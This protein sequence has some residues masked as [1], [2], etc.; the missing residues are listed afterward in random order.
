MNLVTYS[1]SDAGRR[2]GLLHNDF[3]IDLER[4]LT[5]CLENR[6]LSAGPPVPG[7]VLEVVTAPDKER[8]AIEAA[9]GTVAGLR[10][11]RLD[12]GGEPVAHRSSE[13]ALHAPVPRPRSLR[14]FCAFEA[15]IQRFF[16][17]QGLSAVPREWSQMPLF[18][19]G[20]H[21]AIYGPEEEISKPRGSAWLDFEF[22]IAC[23]IGREGRD[24]RLVDADR[25]LAGYTII[26]DWTAR[27]YQL[28]EMRG[29]MGPHKGKDFAT[30][31]GPA[32][33]TPDELNDRQTAPGRYSLT[34][35]ARV[36]GHEVGRGNFQDIHW[37]FPQMIARASSDTTLYPGD[38]LGS[39]VIGRGCLYDV[40]DGRG[41]WLRPGDVVEL[42][43]E[44]LGILRSRVA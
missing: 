14:L 16:E 20:N 35:V 10:L 30:S 24:I 12:V 44:R 31:L 4:A 6:V 7:E 21:Q 41:P 42:Q 22:G 27:D 32:L 38:V 43:V 25:H 17:L 3:V 36:N 19:Y 11:E 34:M 18:F 40:T 29:A 37:T 26:N 15:G 8:Q 28:S 2:V 1:R 33:V 5:W 13:V 39:G 23:V 9:V